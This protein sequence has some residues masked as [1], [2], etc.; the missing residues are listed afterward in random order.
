MQRYIV[1]SALELGAEMMVPATIV[2]LDLRWRHD[3]WKLRP[4][5]WNRA[6][7]DA[8][9][10]TPTPSTARAAAP[11]DTRT[12]RLDVPQYQT[13]D[14]RRAAEA[15]DHEQQCLTCIGLQHPPTD[16]ADR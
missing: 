9:P 8:G 2:D 13:D 7:E 12:P 15:V 10:A 3:E 14:D 16:R 11:A 5:S 6:R 1:C 4:L